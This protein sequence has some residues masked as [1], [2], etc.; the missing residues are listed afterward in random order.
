MSNNLKIVAE[1]NQFPL[2]G[3]IEV[4]TDDRGG[5]VV[6]MPGGWMFAKPD[7]ENPDSPEFGY[8][9]LTF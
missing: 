7:P 8:C 6:S 1:F 9:R 5:I 2:L 4:F 3:P